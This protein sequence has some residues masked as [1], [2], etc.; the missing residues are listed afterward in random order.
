MIALAVAF[1]GIA[2]RI[3]FEYEHIPNLVSVDTVKN[4]HFDY[5][6]V[7]AG[8]SGSVLS[9]LLTKDTNFSV[10]L[11]EAG[12]VF[13]GLS[14]VPLLCTLMQSTNM[15]WSLKSVP[16]KYSSFGLV[17]RQQSI[18]R[19]KGLGGSSQLNY[20][21]HFG[22][23]KADFDEWQALGATEWGYGNLSPYISHHDSF[24]AK[25]DEVCLSN[26]E[27]RLTI[28]RISSEDSKLV[29]YFVKAGEELK[30]FNP[31]ATFNLAEFT[32]KNGVRRSVYQNYL[33]K[34]FFHKNLSVMMHATV[35]RVEFNKDKEAVSVVVRTKSTTNRIYA[36]KEI[37][38][39]AGSINSPYI[40]QLSGVG[41][42]N[43]LKAA[44]INLVHNAPEVGKN[45]FDHLIFPLFVS[46]NASAS[47]TKSKAMSATEL[48]KFLI[49]GKG[50]FSTTGVI[51]VANSDDHG[52]ILFGVGSSD[53]QLLKDIANYKTE[54][55]RAFFPLHANASQ[56]GF[57]LLSI[58][59]KPKSRGTVKV[60]SK[61][62][63]S[64]P[65]IDPMY[66]KDEEDLNCLKK[67]IDLSSKIVS[68]NNFQEIGAEI[69]W[70]R[71]KDCKDFGENPKNANYL[72]CLLRHGALTSHHF[73][74]TC[75]I[76]KVVD[77]TLR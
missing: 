6:I 52:V 36:N 62:L 11:I 66:L 29:G 64:S 13:N 75:A 23:L 68:T 12:G 43:Y 71:L 51:G 20:L 47:V 35:E 53:E 7:G 50:V 69:H 42:D 60:D 19:G 41:G 76:G 17:N 31:T 74:G 55:F 40:L 26:D 70:P 22:G 8:T 2:F 59:Y 45:L 15:D 77:N 30:S 48:Y 3:L 16:Q 18:P 34:A 32:T 38:L 9:Y 49:H 21:M 28:T 73:G 33:R 25:D 54:T 24:C 10:L 63:G 14:S 1:I 44:G 61:N 5:V 67:A 65:L 58:C 56:E 39:S 27:T 46:I 37:I 4:T 72:Q 57:T